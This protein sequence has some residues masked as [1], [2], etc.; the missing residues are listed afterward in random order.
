MLSVREGQRSSFDSFSLCLC[1]VFHV[2]K[3][4]MLKERKRAQ[5]REREQLN[6]VS[7]PST[8]ID[9]CA[10]ADSPP[11]SL[12][13]STPPAK[14]NSDTP[15][16]SR[17]DLDA[18]LPSLPAWRLS[19]DGTALHRDFRAK[20]F[21]SAVAFLNLAADVAEATG[22]HPDFHLTDWNKV[23]VEATTH[24]AGGVT[25]ADLSLA[26]KL[27][28]VPVTYSPK[29]LREQAKAKEEGK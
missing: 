13:L 29:W 8:L 7:F 9:R 3:L 23:R 22:H 24:A 2:A 4:L 14:H 12:S 25:M 15:L 27:D 10:S 20:N 5:G 6:A 26:A 28:A 18:K 19:A 17:A 1:K 16:L 11:L 21:A